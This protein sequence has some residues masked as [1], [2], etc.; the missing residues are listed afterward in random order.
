MQYEYNIHFGLFIDIIIRAIIKLFFQINF[1]S[2]GRVCQSFGT[3]LVNVYHS[4]S[5][6]IKLY[7]MPLPQ[8]RVETRAL[9]KP[10]Q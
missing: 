8:N 10:L 4:F 3:E 1:I 7:L 6:S 9:H 2:F 5:K